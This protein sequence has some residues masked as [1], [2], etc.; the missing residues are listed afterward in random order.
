VNNQTLETFRRTLLAQRTSLL[1]RWRQALSDENELLAVREPDW[2]DT[3]ATTT[4]IVV[5]DRIGEQERKALARIQSSL[6]RIERG[7]YGECV[8]CHDVI[9]EH[10]LR[11]VPDTDRCGACAPRLN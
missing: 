4:A 6:A 10:R 3:A 11:A 5:L 9:D 8:A 1:A 7:N 2:Q